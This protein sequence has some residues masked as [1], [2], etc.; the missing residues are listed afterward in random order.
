MRNEMELTLRSARKLEKEIANVVENDE[1]QTSGTFRLQDDFENIQKAIEEGQARLRGAIS[2]LDTLLQLRYLIRSAISETNEKAGIN[3]SLATREYLLNKV[4]K[5]EKLLDVCREE[6]FDVI[7]DR[8]ELV[9]KSNET[10][11]FSYM[12]TPTLNVNYLDF[13]DKQIIKNTIKEIKR[14][15][16]S[17][18]DNLVVLN[19]T[20]KITLT[21]EHVELLKKYNLV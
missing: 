3:Q 8:I 20:N 4:K 19:T 15:I 7:Q 5:F 12:V 9:K 14:N 6:D 10:P 1:L 11:K 17:I 13:N 18:D 16:T 2:S 21:E